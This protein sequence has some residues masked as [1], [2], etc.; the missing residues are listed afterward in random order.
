MNTT[1]TVF[2]LMS[3]LLLAILIEPVARRLRVPFSAALVLVGFIGSELVTAQGIDTGLRWYH[4]GELVF[5]ILVPLLVFESAYKMQLRHL[6]KVLVPV[7]LLAIPLLLVSLLITACL[8]YFG[9]GHATGFPWMA[10]FISAL[11]LSATDTTAVIPLLRESGISERLI[12]VL[13]G[14]SLFNDATTIVLFSLLLGLASEM[15]GNNLEYLS[16]HWVS[17]LLKFFLVTCGGLSIGVLVGGLAHL[18]MRKT[19]SLSTR[20]LITLISAYSAWVIADNLLMLSGVM[21]VLACGLLL[22]EMSRRPGAVQ[23]GFIQPF[24]EFNAYCAGALIY[25]L[26]GVTITLEMF[27]SQ[28]LAMLTGIVA[29]LLGRSITTVG[30]L[31]LLGYVPGIKHFHWRERLLFNWS[32]VKGAVTLA[33]ALS[34]PTEL[35]YWYTIQSIAYGVVLFGLFVQALSLPG[36]LSKAD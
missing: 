35:D 13:E 3:M 19:R 26:A 11:I 27:S 32:G 17:L 33:L 30:L 25:L 29:V 28:W 5:F 10:A 8:L 22:G 2:M 7:L 9:I 23:D 14:E 20:G 6:L 34:L 4:F 16:T 18:L 21:S 15:S 1:Q 12:S 31:G 36:L 24:W